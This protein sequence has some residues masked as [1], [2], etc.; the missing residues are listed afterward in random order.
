MMVG[1]VV[2]AD[3]FLGGTITYRPLNLSATGSPIAIVITQTYSWSYKEVV[4]TNNMISNSS[5]IPSVGGTS[6]EKLE[7]VKNC[8]IDAKGYTNVSVWP[9][10]TDISVPIGTTGSQRTDTVYL[11]SGDDFVVA[12]KGGSWR[13]LTTVYHGDWSLAAHFKIQP[14]PD[15]GLYNNAPITT[16][17][18]PVYVSFNQTMAIHLPVTDA[19]GDVVRCRWANK[20]NGIDECSSVCPPSSLPPNTILFPNCT[21]ITTG[22]NLSDWYAVAV[23]VRFLK[24]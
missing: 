5:Q 20:S 22:R 14:R 18:S 8:G 2:H 6:G 19:D 3:H 1:T 11:D 9:A 16:V 24:H 23:M 10:C 4:C 13:N 15:N 7:C 12:F 17:M 21:I